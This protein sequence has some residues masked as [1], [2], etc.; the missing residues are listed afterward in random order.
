MNNLNHALRFR[1]L[2]LRMAEQEIAALLVTH[3]ADV[4]Y[5]CGF[6]GSNAALAITASSA[7]LYTDG[8]Y[9]T[10]ARQ[11]TK[12]AKVVI[13]QKSALAECCAFLAASGVSQCF[14]DGSHTSVAQ[15]RA[16]QEAIKEAVKR[17]VRGTR[18]RGFFKA[19]TKPIV[20][21]LRMIKDAGEL[22]R[23][24]AAALLG[25]R[26]F[27]ELLSKIEAGKSEISIAAELEYAARMAGAE[28][29]SFDTIV[30]AGPRAAL[31]HGVASAARI[32]PSGFIVLDFG[33]ILEGYCSDMT[34]TVF[35]GDASPRE[36]FAYDSVLEAQQ[37]AI[38]AVKAG[39]RCSDV[40]EAACSVL[41]RAKLEKYFTHST[42]HGV[43]LEIHEPPRI[44]KEQEEL[45]KTGMVITIEPGV[46]LAGKFGIR[47]EDMVVVTESGG[48]VLTPAQK[49]LIEL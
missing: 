9:K 31:P 25:C 45:L 46:Y 37:A 16:M 38:D 44:A 27:E 34:R 41:R 15:L 5:L 23:M 4:R 21:E 24:E 10:Q 14:F 17:V 36:R 19:L 40:H 42:G 22:A 13:A 39:V 43:G 49:A 11:E 6:T 8:R 20:A 7:V 35:L 3:L 28:G 29:M 2:R 18:R 30:A 12:S 48:R 33:I 1:A 26:L 32:R 47:I